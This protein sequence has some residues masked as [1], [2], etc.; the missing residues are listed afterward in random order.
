[1]LI[2]PAGVFVLGVDRRGADA[3]DVGGLGCP[4]QRILEQTHTDPSALRSAADREP[5]QQPDRHG[6]AGQACLPDIVM[7]N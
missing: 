5:R 3:G 6:M 4:Q 1:M 2:E 7:T